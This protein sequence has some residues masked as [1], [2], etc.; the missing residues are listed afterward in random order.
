[1]NRKA[2]K[3]VCVRD[4]FWSGVQYKKGD[5]KVFYSALKRK[6]FLEKCPLKCFEKML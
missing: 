6:H 3:L 4:C 2:Y 1:M 5:V